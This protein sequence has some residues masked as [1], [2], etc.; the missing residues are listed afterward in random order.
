MFKQE[1]SANAKVNARQMCVY[2]G[3][4]EEIYGKSKQKT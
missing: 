4:S 1:S 2:E 3:H